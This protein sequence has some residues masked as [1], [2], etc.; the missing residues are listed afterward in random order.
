[1]EYRVSDVELHEPRLG[2]HPPELRFE[3]VPVLTP[4]VVEDQKAALEKVVAEALRL[5]VGLGPVPGLRHVGEWE[6]VKFRVTQRQHVAAVWTLERVQV[7]DFVENL[8]QVALGI[9]VIVSPRHIAATEERAAAA[10]SKAHLVTQPDEDESTVVLSIPWRGVAETAG[11]GGSAGDKARRNER[12]DCDDDNGCRALRQC[13][14]TT[15]S[16]VIHRRQRRERLLSVVQHHRSCGAL[17]AV[18]SS[19]ISRLLSASSIM[20]RF[21]LRLVLIRVGATPNPSQIVN[22]RLELLP[23]LIESL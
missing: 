10:T 16:R 18:S 19:R 8:R 17:L 22:P 5:G 4:K 21:E 1:M 23:L 6:L 11:A 9:G 7:G 12:G 14:V 20:E 3:V 2:Q 15:T 13:R